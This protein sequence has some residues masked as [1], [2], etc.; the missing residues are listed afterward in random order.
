VPLN[1][2]V[3]FEKHRKKKK[4][5]LYPEEKREHWCGEPGFYTTHG[6]I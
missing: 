3:A 4:S 6:N 5:L 2:E 1:C